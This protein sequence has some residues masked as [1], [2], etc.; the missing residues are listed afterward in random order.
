MEDI[1]P[2]EEIEL[3]LMLR[4]DKPMAMFT[5]V[6]PLE[7]GIV[8]EE[9][10]R[11]YVESGKFIMRERYEPAPSVPG[12]DGEV[13]IRRVLYA[14]PEQAWRIEAMLLLCDVYASQGG[15][16]E[17]LERMTGKL[18]GYGDKQIEAFIRNIRK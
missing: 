17:G 8:P 13:Q 15:W 14:L 16:D 3:M 6:C 11:P 10:F 12:Y 5:E 18:L 9:E 7:T 4:G 2:H 1:G